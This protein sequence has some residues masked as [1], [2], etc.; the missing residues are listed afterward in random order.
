MFA[1][2]PKSTEASPRRRGASAARL[3]LTAT[4][5]AANG[6]LPAGDAPKLL[7]VSDVPPRLTAHSEIDAVPETIAVT[8][9]EVGTAVVQVRQADGS[10][11]PVLERTGELPPPTE[12]AV[13]M[14]ISIDQ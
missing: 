2:Q 5:A 9:A 13:N 14:N 8:Q 12:A 10:A 6:L 4:L 11:G 3:A 7:P 1:Q